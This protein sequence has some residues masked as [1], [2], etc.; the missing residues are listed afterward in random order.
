VLRV[1]DA[2]DVL[3][4]EVRLGLVDHDLD[5]AREL[6]AKV[7]HARDLTKSTTMN[8]NVS[9]V[10]VNKDARRSTT[11]N[12]QASQT[13][14]QRQAEAPS[15]TNLILR[16]DELRGV[17]LAVEVEGALERRVPVREHPVVEE[18]LSQS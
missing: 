5:V 8:T 13:A 6:Q 12:A 17:V 18:H 7:V 1:V 2:L 10:S 4:V 9:L 3:R 15:C 11:S 16:D 14:P